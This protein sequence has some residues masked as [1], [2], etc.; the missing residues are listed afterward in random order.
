LYRQPFEIS[1]RISAG[2]NKVPSAS[3][4]TAEVLCN[5]VD[6]ILIVSAAV[7]D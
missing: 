4:A 1:I 6:D 2:I 5:L 3:S 7:R